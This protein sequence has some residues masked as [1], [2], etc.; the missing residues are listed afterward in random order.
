MKIYDIRKKDGTPIYFYIYDR[1]IYHETTSEV[2]PDVMNNISTK[3]DK[4]QHTSDIDNTNR[5]FVSTGMNKNVYSLNKYKWIEYPGPNNIYDKLT[6]TNYNNEFYYTIDR[7][8]GSI[9]PTEKP[10]VFF[11]VNRTLRNPICVLRDDGS[12]ISSNY[13]YTYNDLK[14]MLSVYN[15]YD[16]YIKNND[17]I[18]LVIDGKLYHMRFN[19]DTYYGYSYKDGIIPHH[20]DMISDEI[21]HFGQPQFLDI[22]D[23]TLSDDNPTKSIAGDGS[24]RS[25]FKRAS[26]KLW[27]DVQHKLSDNLKSHII[28]KYAIIYDRYIGSPSSNISNYD[29][30]LGYVW[31]L[32]EGEIFGYNRLSNLEAD[33]NTCIQ[34]PS[35]KYTG[36]IRFKAMDIKINSTKVSGDYNTWSL[37]DNRNASIC[38]NGEGNLAYDESS[39]NNRGKLLCFRFA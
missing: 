4:L 7:V 35:C 13:G 36:L 17:Y 2:L 37:L 11:K 39:Q 15:D 9:K 12:T 23:K 29:I 14:N 3:Y 24:F 28:E 10:S 25:I 20:I 19:I 16:Q 8:G 21:L 26:D 22:W 30:P 33:A 18:E 32:R 38:I 1:Y 5:Q 27:T 34:Y 6:V 31:Q